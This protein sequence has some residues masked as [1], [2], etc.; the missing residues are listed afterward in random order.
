MHEAHARDSSRISTHV[1]RGTTTRK[2]RADGLLRQCSLRR[3][4]KFQVDTLSADESL[5]LLQSWAFWR[6]AD[7]PVRGCTRAAGIRFFTSIQR[8]TMKLSLWKG[9]L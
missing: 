6:C 2:W 4:S 5:Y 8:P 7:A 3:Y 1:R 9:L